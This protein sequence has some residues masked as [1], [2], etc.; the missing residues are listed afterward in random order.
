MQKC[1]AIG[2]ISV[3]STHSF[4]KTDEAVAYI[5][6]ECDSNYTKIFTI[7]GMY[8]K[9]FDELEKETDI[10]FFA[11]TKNVKEVKN[12]IENHSIIFLIVPNTKEGEAHDTLK[13]E[14]NK[15]SI[16]QPLLKAVS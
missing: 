5:M 13:A 10:P 11:I 16:E 9:Q 4:R 7:K 15:N 12:L 2:S 14:L 3:Q 6:K 8:L 1:F